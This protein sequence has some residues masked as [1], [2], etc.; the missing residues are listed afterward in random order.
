ML[1]GKCD[2]ASG[3]GAEAPNFTV[4]VSVLPALEYGVRGTEQSEVS[5][6]LQGGLR[7]LEVGDHWGPQNPQV[8][9]QNDG[10]LKTNLV[11]NGAHNAVRVKL[12]M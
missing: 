12:G 7:R 1:P 5:L 8:A 6:R 10:N 3:L 11:E 2:S 4:V 9:G